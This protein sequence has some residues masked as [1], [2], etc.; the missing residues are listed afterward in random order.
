[1][2]RRRCEQTPDLLSWKPPAVEARFDPARVR[3][4]TPQAKVARVLSEALKKD[5]RSREQIAAALS[6][7]LGE[8]VRRDSL[9]AWA[10]E[11]REGSNIAAY[12]LMALAGLLNSKELLNE[13][14]D[15]TGLVVVEK[16]YAPLITKQL[17]L[18]QQERLKKMARQC[19]TDLRRAR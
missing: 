4:A 18:E 15:G 10:S 17:I 14:L 16:R 8:S 3:A 5:G 1:M 7:E 13:L 12:R 19:D 6:R 9:D 11:A 2:R